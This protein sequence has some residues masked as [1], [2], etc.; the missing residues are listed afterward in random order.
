LPRVKE[1]S[2]KTRRPINLSLL[3]DLNCYKI[4]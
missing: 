1:E 3:P 4:K 2:A